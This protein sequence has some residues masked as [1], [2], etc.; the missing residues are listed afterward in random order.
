MW[1]YCEICVSCAHFHLLVP[2]F[3]RICALQLAKPIYV[4]FLVSFTSSISMFIC[5][6]KKIAFD[7]TS[8]YTLDSLPSQNERA[9]CIKWSK[10]EI[11][12]RYKV[13]KKAYRE[14][15]L[16]AAAR[17]S[18]RMREKKI[19]QNAFYTENWIRKR[20]WQLTKCNNNNNKINETEKC[21]KKWKCEDKT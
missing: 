7:N 18:Q 8:K 21:I 3:S 6:V 19:V 14:N 17:N 15:H 5:Q 12:I 16:N 2:F 4:F 1:I 20:K 13:H 10:N 11:I 9:K